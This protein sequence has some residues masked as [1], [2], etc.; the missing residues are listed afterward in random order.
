MRH[1]ALHHTVITATTLVLGCGASGAIAQPDVPA[2]P[3][4]NVPS[5][6][7][8]VI[9]QGEPLALRLDEAVALMLRHNRTVRSAYL[10]RVAERFDLRASERAFIPQALIGTQIV[11]RRDAEGGASTDAVVS[12]GVSWRTPVGTSVS[13]VW[14]QRQSLHEGPDTGWGAATLSVSQ[15]L[16]R[17]AGTDV[18]M[19]PLR[20]AR[21]QERIN[22]LQLQATVS[23]EIAA[24]IL[25]YRALVQAQEQTRLAELSLERSQAILATNEALIEAGRMAAADIVQTE[26]AVAGQEL[27]VLQARQQQTSAQLALLQRLAIDPGVNVIA[28]D[29][30]E[31]ERVPIDFD[32]ALDYALSARVDVLAQ[33]QALEQMR[34]SLIMARNDRLLDVSVTASVT[35]FGDGDRF[36]APLAGR[37]DYA[38]G[39]RVEIPIGDIS[40]RQNEI[41]AEMNVRT[42]E[43]RQE[44]LVQG[45]HTQ[46]RDAIQNVE[47]SWRQVEAA[48]RRQTLAE[49]ALDIQLERLRF[50]RGSNFETLSLQADLRAADTQALTAKIAYLNALTALDQQIGSTLETWQVSLN[51]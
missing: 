7:G 14:D 33:R 22:Q 43:L 2:S 5:P 15:P 47:A 30:I 29:T 10:Q 12:T 32:R 39:L 51:D 25:A 11:T 44:D 46:V 18:N 13:F 19:A 41:R 21:L 6:Q 48:Q 28:I 42:A 1:S 4:A 3:I 16:R 9:P 17:G 49:R 8:V 26:S 34:H 45:V 37:T 40:R 24:V 38:A 50:G 36:P 35:R 31:A 20:I 23:N 27:A